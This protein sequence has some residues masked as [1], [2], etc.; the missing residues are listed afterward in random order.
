MASDQGR[1]AKEECIPPS[2]QRGEINELGELVD[3]IIE[4]GGADLRKKGDGSRDAILKIIAGILGIGLDDLKEE[5]TK[6]GKKNSSVLSSHLP[7]LP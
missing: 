4:P 7:F 2:Q 1:S 3:Q 5:I 6:N